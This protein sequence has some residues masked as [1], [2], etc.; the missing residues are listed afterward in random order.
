MGTWDLGP[1]DSSDVDSGSGSTRYLQACSDEGFGIWTQAWASAESL[2]RGAH[3]KLKN[4]AQDK[5]DSRRD[6]F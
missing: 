5:G 1:L 4:K 3:G 6:R 2:S